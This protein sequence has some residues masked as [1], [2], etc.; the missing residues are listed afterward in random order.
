MD[1]HVALA[2]E[3]RREGG[4]STAVA[5]HTPGPWTIYPGARGFGMIRDQ[6][7][8]KVCSFGYAELCGDEA[9]AN[10][11]LIA[12]APDMK[13]ALGPLAMAARKQAEILRH[14]AHNSTEGVARTL[15]EA[16]ERWEQL[17][18]DAAAAI[19]KA[20]LDQTAGA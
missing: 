17:H 7:H 12:A 8:L 13:A 18:D 15:I 2:A 20:S 19:A 16:A 10:A 11:R 6:N 4:S 14:Q 9:D 5:K 1:N 3:K